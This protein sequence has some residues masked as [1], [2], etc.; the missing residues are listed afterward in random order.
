MSKEKAAAATLWSG[1]DILL[2]QGVQFFIS[3]TLARLL[4]PSDFGVIA[5][6][7][8]FTSLSTYFVDSGMSVALIRCQ[9]SRQEEETSIFWFNLAV[10]LVCAAALLL[11]APYVAQFYRQPVLQ[12]LMG[13]AA[14]QVIITALGAVHN[15]LLMRALRF[16]ELLIVGVLA[17]MVSGGLG[18]GLAFA[19]FGVWSLAW[20]MLAMSATT[21]LSLWLVGGWRPSPS[22]RF[23]HVWGKLQ[24]GVNLVLSNLLDLSYNQGFSAIVGKLYGMEDLGFYN[25]G[26]GVQALASGMLTT[27]IGRVSLPLFSARANDIAALRRGVSLALRASM[28]INVPAMIGLAVLSDLVVVTLFGEKWRSS[29]PI[30][31]ALALYG[32]LWPIHVINLQA[33]LACGDSRAFLRSGI[34]KQATGFITMVVG[35]F[36]GIMGLAWSQVVFGVIAAFINAAPTGRSLNYGIRAQLTDLTGTFLVGA[37]MGAAVLFARSVLAFSPPL[38]LVAT[39]IVGA[40][41]YL[42][43]GLALRLPIFAEAMS[44]LR[45]LGPERGALR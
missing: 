27:L 43:A 38:E 7:T 6:L 21:T 35:S 28:A 25:R 14:A 37:L 3:L 34:A 45:R 19:G 22:F 24:F 8:L 33:M 20:Q 42:G 23:S 9:N 4:S 31:S 15:T 36:F 26:S 1:A 41:V 5:L 44:I 17:T 30:L 29:A 12:P 2:R 39:A 40:I 13:V 11:V 18:I 16:R 10:G 32:L